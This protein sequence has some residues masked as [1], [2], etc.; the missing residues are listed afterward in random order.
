[1]N[2]MFSVWK[3]VD[4]V[5]RDIVE[6]AKN[7]IGSSGKVGHAGTLDPFAEGVLVLC[8]GTKTKEVP[9][10]MAMKKEYLATIKLGVET[11]T[12]DSTGEIYKS[13]IVP[14]IDEK[15]I[16]KV[17]SK[18]KGDINQTPPAFSALKLNGKRLYEYARCGIRIIKKPRK[19]TISSLEFIK[20]NSIDTIVVKVVCSSGTYIR[21]LAADIAVELG[22]R[23]HLKE[24]QRLRI[25][26]YTKEKCISI[27]ELINGNIV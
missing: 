20:L 2:T 17:L 16:N 14:D 12:L 24:L 6:I 15:S 27:E 19:V 3:P 4:M 18:F 1:M 9:N 26:N 11:D 5:S 25:G 22:T 23:G 21:S 7:K 8:C 10:I 13:S